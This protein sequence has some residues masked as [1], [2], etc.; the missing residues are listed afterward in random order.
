MTTK[1]PPV[2][3]YVWRARCV[4]IVDGDTVDCDLDTGFGNVLTWRI[5]FFGVDAPELHTGLLKKEAVEA[6]VFIGDVIAQWQADPNDHWP[7]VADVYKRDS[8]FRY[9]TNLF[10]RNTLPSINDMLLESGHAV[11]FY[12]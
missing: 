1:P 4:N 11:V 9:L 8:F 12:K 5:R 7:L 2:P 10:K 6:M 3:Q